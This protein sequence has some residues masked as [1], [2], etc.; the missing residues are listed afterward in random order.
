[1]S[2][3]APASAGVRFE[4]ERQASSDYQPVATPPYAGGAG[5]DGPTTSAEN[6]WGGEARV[7]ARPKKW[8][9]LLR[10]YRVV[11]FAGTGVM[12]L[13]GKALGKWMELN[14]REYTNCLGIPI[15]V[16][17]LINYGL[18]KCR[19]VRVIPHDVRDFLLSLGQA[20]TLSTI[21]V[22]FTKNATGRF[23]PCFFE[24]C[25]WNYD[26]IW[27]GVTNLCSD[28]AGER[29][30]RKSFPSGH[31]SFA[32]S[33]ML[34]LSA[35]LQDAI[36]YSPQ[37]QS[38]RPRSVD[39]SQKFY[40]NQSE[41]F[42]SMSEEAVKKPLFVRYP[43]RSFTTESS[44]F[45]GAASS[46]ASDFPFMASSSSTAALPPLSSSE[47]HRNSTRAKFERFIRRY[48]VTEFAITVLMYGFALFFAKIEVAQRTPQLNPIAGDIPN[49]QVRLNSTTSVW[50]R[51]PTINAK[52]HTQQVPMI[53]LVGIG[54]GV[55][56]IINLVI[57]Y[58]LPKCRP[59]RIIPHDTRDF[60][61]SLLQSTSMATLLTQFT[62]NMTGR[63]RPCFYDMCGWDYDIIWDGVTNLCT[64]ASGEKEGRKSFPSGHASFAWSTM[65][66]LTVR[67]QQKDPSIY[68]CGARRKANESY[69]HDC[70]SCICWDDRR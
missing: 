35:K 53:A 39:E 45:R 52:E 30:G 63:F 41:H 17:L 40:S 43:V 44:A 19:E 56:I 11:E 62:K 3:E 10:E 65:L 66:M 42:I 14:D 31:S 70:C 48:R 46:S 28:V 64:S 69:L 22:N 57:N 50:S 24:L 29:D 15:V 61:L 68:D 32:W 12:Y 9:R 67:G 23:R 49:I 6:V 4:R 38:V 59:V 21:L 47:T 55:P 54:G 8:Q 37:H 51:D 60:L 25:G 16:N 26:V 7:F 1:M 27:D 20:V 36:L 58:A 18:P 5:S 2:S 34:V 13:V 33:T